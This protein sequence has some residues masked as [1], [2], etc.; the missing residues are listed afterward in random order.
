M[1]E[2]LNALLHSLFVFLSMKMR[3]S[4]FVLLTKRSPRKQEQLSNSLVQLF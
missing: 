1:R 4:C 2:L 3:I